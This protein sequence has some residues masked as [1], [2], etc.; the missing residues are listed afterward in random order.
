M[1]KMKTVAQNKRIFGLK[2][3]LRLEHE[4][5]REIAFLVS[6]GR[7]ERISELRYT[8]A[9][10]IIK[11][12]ESKLPKSNEPSRRT[13]NYHKQKAGIETLV[14]PTMLDLMRT[15]WRK[16][17][18]R[19]DEGLEALTLRIIKVTK[20]RTTKECSKVIEAIKSM[21]SRPANPQSAIQ[22]K[23]DAA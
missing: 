3:E 13:V 1:P 19:T 8:E 17:E 15:L 11:T 6:D 18:G 4:D 12:L 10:L 14:T 2:R 9:D 5:L 22:K 16:V 20:P 23:E 7:V 21:N